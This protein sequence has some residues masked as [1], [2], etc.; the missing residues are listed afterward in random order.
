MRPLSDM[1]A[2]MAVVFPPG[3]AQHIQDAIA[4]A[5]I[6]EQRHEL[7]RLVLHDEQAVRHHAVRLAQR[8]SGL[9]DERVGRE[10]AGHDLDLLRARAGPPAPRE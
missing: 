1:A 6:D 3:D 5:G 7:R 8:L 4:G 10:A 2:A 9:D